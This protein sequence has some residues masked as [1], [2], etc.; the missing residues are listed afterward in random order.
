MKANYGGQINGQGI[1]ADL[2]RMRK[3]KGVSLDAL[4]EKTGVSFYVIRNIEQGYVNAPDPEVIR[5]LKAA[6]ES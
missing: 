4:A 1:G 5:K 2:Q 6:L 3:I